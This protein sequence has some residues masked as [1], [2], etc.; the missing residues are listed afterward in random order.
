MKIGLIMSLAILV[1]LSSLALAVEYKTLDTEYFNVEYPED[2]IVNE[3]TGD[4]LD[5]RFRLGYAWYDFGIPFKDKKGSLYSSNFIQVGLS[6]VEISLDVDPRLKYMFD[7]DDSINESIIH[8]LKTFKV[9]K[10]LTDIVTTSPDY[11]ILETDYFKAEYPADWTLSEYGDET[12]GFWASQ[13]DGSK[14]EA[15]MIAVRLNGIRIR[16]MINTQQAANFN[17]DG[18]IN[19]S[20]IHLLE[21]F[22]VKT[23]DFTPKL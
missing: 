12:Y 14:S 22:K 11:K 15:G 20:L 19:E 21:T 6:G 8:F 17:K 13:K 18:S 4:T 3:G 23:S 16:L 10:P 9:K 2:W 5:Y 1:V 7:E